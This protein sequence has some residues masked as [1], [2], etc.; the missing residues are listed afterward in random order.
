MREALLSRKLHTLQACLVLHALFAISS[1]AAAPD[2][3]WQTNVAVSSIAFS[4]SG[5]ELA[6]G[7]SDQFVRVWSLSNRT[8]IAEMLNSDDVTSV[9]LASD[10]TF[11]VAGCDDGTA[12]IWSTT[13]TLSCG[14]S[15]NADIVLSVATARS[16]VAVARSKGIVQLTLTP[17]AGGGISLQGHERDVFCVAL[18]PDATKLASASADGTARIWRVSDGA[19]LQTLSGHSYFAPEDK[20]DETVINPVYSVAFSPNGEL[21]ATSGADGTA[22]IWRVL[23]GEALHVLQGGGIPYRAY[24]GSLV[25]FSC[26]GKSLYTLA[27]GVI[28]LWRVMD[29]RLLTTYDN[30][31]ANTLSVNP[32]GK[33]FA[34]G[35]GGTLVL[36]RVPLWIEEIQHTGSQVV[37]RWQGGTGRYQLQQRA[38]LSAGQWE[39]VGNPTTATSVTNAVAGSVFYRLQS[40]P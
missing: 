17:C 11:V 5:S 22:R 1:S 38:N 19:S 30:T 28:T 26:D 13:G 7:G 14:S 16:V 2:I 20:E 4:A 3:V 27:A 21:L 10:S 35:I 12:R 6:T 34:Y 24:P 23:D 40:L 37:L 25:K 31:G 39:N 29:G 33:T 32:D 18:S 8:A 15:P 36:A 9:A